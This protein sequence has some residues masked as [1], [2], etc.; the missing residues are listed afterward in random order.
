MNDFRKSM[1]GSGA[2]LMEQ[3]ANPSINQYSNRHQKDAWLRFIQQQAV[4]DVRADLTMKQSAKFYT[5]SIGSS[6]AVESKVSLTE[7]L[8]S[9]NLHQFQ[10]RLNY[11]VFKHAF[12]RYGKR[13]CVVSV[14]QGRQQS[15]H[16]IRQNDLRENVPVDDDYK[17]LHYHLLLEQPVHYSFD[18][19]ATEIR[20]CWRATNFGYREDNIEPI[21]H[22]FGS[23]KYNL[24]SGTDTIDLD[25]TYMNE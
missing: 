15:G 6:P 11:A 25:N 3:F 19:F 1:E 16:K 13:L 9:V 12:K 20:R 8:A 2:A 23:A 22:L 24:K 18:D 10:E 17:R 4:V 21:H 5:P 14:L 7:A